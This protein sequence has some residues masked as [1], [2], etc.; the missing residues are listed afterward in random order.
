MYARFTSCKC[1][2]KAESKV[3]QAENGHSGSVV[4][5]DS[6]LEALVLPSKSSTACE[7]VQTDNAADEGPSSGDFCPMCQMPFS[8]LVVQTMAW[9]VA[10]CLD[11]PRDTCKECPDGLQCC[12]A[13]P[14]HYK[15]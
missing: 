6:S 2:Q 4:N 11:T 10:E 14:N 12:S 9:H 15:K 13:I 5:G 8:I 3:K 1:D 7:T